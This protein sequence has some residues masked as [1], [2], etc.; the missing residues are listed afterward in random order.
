MSN[1]KT[2]YLNDSQTTIKVED[3][4]EETQNIGRSEV[5]VRKYV[6]CAECDYKTTLNR[7]MKTH[8]RKKHSLEIKTECVITIEDDNKEKQKCNSLI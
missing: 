3:R 6:N 7:A 2:I 1:R 5:N 8:K 4:L